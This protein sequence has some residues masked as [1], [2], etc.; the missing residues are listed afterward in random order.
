MRIVF[1]NGSEFRGS[2][3]DFTRALWHP[4]FISLILAVTAIILVLQPYDRFL[5]EGVMARTLIIAS[6]VIVF[7]ACLLICAGQSRRLPIF[8]ST[9]PII[10]FCVCITSAWGVGVSSVAGG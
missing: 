9:V 2:W 4:L 5:P 7:I 8:V 3:H 10:T 1:L 6:A